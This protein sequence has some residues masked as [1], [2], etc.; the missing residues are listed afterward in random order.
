M[1]NKKTEAEERNDSLFGNRRKMAFYSLYVIIF[2]T[3]SITIKIL[4]NDASTVE[5]YSPILSWG[6]SILG[7]VILAFIGA[8]SVEQIAVPGDVTK[9]TKTIEKETK[10]D[11]DIMK[12]IP[13]GGAATKINEKTTQVTTVSD[14]K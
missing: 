5:Q 9:T 14:K 11:P 6:L 4:M 1:A 10:I 12:T 8:A 2:V 3:V 13:P 7:G